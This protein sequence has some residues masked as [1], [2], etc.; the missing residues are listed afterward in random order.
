[1]NNNF[2]HLKVQSSYSL[3]ES[4]IR[5]NQAVNLAKKFRMPA[6]SLTDRNNLFGSLE[7]SITALKEGVQPIHG[8]IAT[9]AYEY[10]NKPAF[11]EMILIATNDIGL[12]NLLKLAS[13]P[14]IK[15]DRRLKDHI[16]IDDLVSRKNGII[17]IS[18]YQNS[19]IAKHIANDMPFVKHHAQ[20]FKDKFQNN[21]YFEITRHGT[22]SEAAIEAAYLNLANDLD[23][24]VVATNNVLFSDLMM[25]DVHDVLLCVAQGVKKYSTNRISSNNQCYFKSQAEMSNLFADLPE[26][27]ANSFYIAQRCS[28]TFS[29]S[30]PILPK[31]TNDDS[32]GAFLKQKAYEGLDTRLKIKFSIE[33]T[34]AEMQSMIK[35]QYFARL[36]YE[37]AVICEMDFAG[38]FLIVSD[39][40]LW[41]KQ[42]EIAVGPGRGSGAGSIV[43]W[44]LQI[45][46]LDPIRFGLIFERFLNP[47][48]ISMPDFDIDFCQER[49]DEVIS[50]VSNKYGK[51]KVAHIITFGSM[52]AKGV[53][54]DV[55]RALDLRYK[56][57]DYL[58]ELVP[59]NAVNP[60]TLSQAIEE[61]GELKNIHQGNGFYSPE[62]LEAPTGGE[63][64]EEF[65]KQLKEVLSVSLQLEGLHRHVST[66]AAGVVI[67]GRDLIEI[68][69]LY[70]DKNSKLPVV[71]YSMK[72]AELS[73][74]VKFDFLGLQTLTVISN[75]L[76]LLKHDGIE[77]DIN[78]I[79][80]DD[81]DVYAM[82][83]RGSTVGIFQ[84]E[85]AGMRDSIKKLKPDRIDDLMALSALYRPG[86]MDNIPTYIACK[87]GKQKPN[88][89]HPLLEDVL[90]DTYGVIIYQE[91]VLEVAR[92]LAGYSLGKA[93]L[94]R[95]AMGKKIK[96]EMDAQ[97]EMFIKGS[98]ANGITE[99]KAKEIFALVEKF[100]GYGF[101]KAHAAAYGVISYQTAYL[102]THYAI[103]FLLAALN[104]DISD[105]DKIAVF[106]NEA[107][108]NDKKIIPVDINLSQGYF[109]ASSD[110]KD[111]I[112]IAFGSIKGV[113]PSFGK[114]IANERLRG[115]PFQSIV[116]FIE[117]IPSSSINRKYL[118]SL[119]KAGCFDSL[120]P[121]RMQLVDSID[122]LLAHSNS[123]HQDRL[124]NQ[125][126]LL[127]KPSAL[128][129]LVKDYE[130]AGYLEK[131]MQEFSVLGNFIR[132]HPISFYQD[133]L[134]EHNILSSKDLNS[135][136]DGNRQ[137]KI[138]AVIQ[139][140]DTRMSAR[141]RFITLQLSD[142]Y[143]IFE[144]SIFNEETIKLY[145]DLLNIQQCAIFN[146]DIQKDEYSI[147]M[148]LLSIESMKELTKHKIH[149]IKIYLQEDEL[150]GVLHFLQSKISYDKLNAKI[151][152]ILTYNQCFLLNLSLPNI[153]YLEMQDR[154]YLSKYE[155]K[156]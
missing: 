31:F 134:R 22:T 69:P 27:I 38:Y 142:Q 89:L 37:L 119:I 53:I 100:A 127:G 94:L 137:I 114:E 24:P 63:E 23:I 156:N 6:L 108:K 46:D 9:V 11:G 74:L 79:P 136:K 75:C 80:L 151:Q 147:R 73:G 145:N 43:A 103:Y 39:F 143:G 67:A 70:A 117:R 109:A 54:K 93:D 98:I 148:I 82:L 122:R 123:Y 18:C 51:E 49:R 45:T 68:V 40:I 149:D 102:K 57:A 138:A 105:H 84:F 120:H 90:K 72:Y 113:T 141:G 65:N 116:D 154:A 88:Y 128:D 146:C 59:F 121:E 115:G 20:S 83:S 26:T 126:S 1:M 106:I 61:V 25:H 87:H 5:I 50:Y 107:K 92:V 86:P 56:Y 42:Q 52:Q 150:A 13:Y 14:Y 104:L 76:K 35:N 81:K 131:S 58:T 30:G 91:Q 3:L 12:Q 125:L 48:R 95:R 118:E 124:S 55:S 21:L 140:K 16:T 33:G 64:L 85:S 62:S 129:I 2:I 153:F 130:D 77:I 139:K 144:V 15:N 8:M 19:L 152:V 78:T 36:D 71:Q 66:H 32:E 7:F 110:D 10:D 99:F 44:S 96:S 34:S 97:Q 29:T 28:S 155:L 41:S 60:V 101:N 132:F 17:V 4:T 135:L 112:L 111:A 47:E 133:F